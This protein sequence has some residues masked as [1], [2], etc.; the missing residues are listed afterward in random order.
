MFLLFWGSWL[1]EGKAQTVKS[2]ET[3]GGVPWGIVDRLATGFQFTEGP[4][5]H[6]AGFLLFSDVQ[7][8]RIIKWTAPN[9]TET[10]RQPSGN[11][12]GLV[13]DSEGRLVACEHSNRR[14]SRTESGGK[15]S[16]LAG[17]YDGKRLNSPNDLAIKSD[18][19]IYFTDPPYG[20]SSSEK[21]LPFNGVFRVD[22]GGQLSL[23][24]EDF[25]RPNG[26]GFSPDETKLY[27]ADTTRG[28]IRVFDVQSDG[29]LND[30]AVFVQVPGPDGMKVDSKGNLYVASS[31]GVAVFA[32]EGELIGTIGFP[33]QPANC[34]FGD[35]DRKTL[36]VTARTS[37]YRVRVSDSEVTA[38]RKRNLSVSWRSLPGKTYDVYLSA[39]MSMWE[40]AA[41]SLESA[42]GAVT[43]WRDATAPLISPE[44][45]RRFY[46]IG[47]RK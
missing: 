27:I 41:E 26:L 46:R 2:E 15:V 47:E 20:I 38:D 21:E 34:C 40:V 39:D 19:S 6:E 22:P 29:S 9:E 23:L 16:T 32:G 13:F 31:N 4:V 28:H 43:T 42:D 36:Y 44:V 7:G 17:T 1:A 45:R 25:D 8:N 35:K 5:W 18:G 11:S 37:L 3:L 12:N 10:F 24:V 30:G 33:E 14:I